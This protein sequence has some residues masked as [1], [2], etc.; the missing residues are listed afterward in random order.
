[1]QSSLSLQQTYTSTL[2]THI[3]TIYSKI[4]KLQQQ[5]TQHCMYPHNIEVQQID[6]VQIKAPKYDPDIDGNKDLHNDNK[7]ATVSV[8]NV[9][10]DNH[11]IPDLIVYSRHYHNLL[12]SHLNQLA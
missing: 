1:M 9:L 5:V 4:A 6:V 8:Q 2:S 7:H 10:D 11:S 12:R 3:T